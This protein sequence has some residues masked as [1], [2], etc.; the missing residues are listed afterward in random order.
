M[1]MPAVRAVGAVQIAPNQPVARAASTV[2]GDLMVALLLVDNSTVAPTAPTGWTVAYA[3]TG[4]QPRFHLYWKIA[5]STEPA[6]YTW[7]YPTVDDNSIAAGILTVE[8]GTFNT[9]TPIALTTVNPNTGDVSASVHTHPGL[10]TTQADA[11]AF[12]MFGHRSSSAQASQVG[13]YDTF[14]TG[15]TERI[16]SRSDGWVGLALATEQ[17]PTAGATGARSATW[18]VGGTATA[19]TTWRTLGFVVQGS[20]GGLQLTSS[21]SD[22]AAITD[23]HT[24]VLAANRTLTD[25]AALTDSATWSLSGPTAPT[26]AGTAAVAPPTGWQSFTP[27]DVSAGGAFILRN[28][29]DY[30]VQGQTANAN[31][32]LR[33]GR[34]VVVMGLTVNIEHATWTTVGEAETTGLELQENPYASTDARSGGDPL[35]DRAFHAEGVYLGGSRLT[36][37]IRL[38]C[39]T[40]DVRIVNSHVGM[41]RF[42]NSDHRDG[43]N[44][45]ST[46]H[47]DVIQTYGGAKS[48]TIDGL[49][50]YSA[51]Q[52]LFFK[53]DNTIVG[54]PI[55][56]RR[57]DMHA[58]EYT[59]TERDGATRAYAGHRMLWNYR[60][61]ATT[62]DNVWVQ[63]H[64]RNGWQPGGFYRVRYWNTTT[65][66][67]VD[68]PVPSNGTDIH[69]IA[70]DVGSGPD[71]TGTDAT[72]AY[73]QYTT[74][75]LAGQRIYLGARPGG[76]FVPVAAVGSGYVYGASSGAE[77]R[78]LTD[79]AAITDSA[80]WSMQYGP[81]QLTRSLADS[82]A[83]RDSASWV[84]AEPN[85]KRTLTDSA[86]ITDSASWTLTTPGLGDY[87]FVLLGDRIPRMVFGLGAPV[88]V[89]P[90][91]FDPAYGDLR[92]Q[93]QNA[94]Q[95]DWRRFGADKRTPGVWNWEAWTD[96]RTPAQALDLIDSM[97]EAWDAEYTRETPGDVLALQYKIPGRPVRRLYGRPRNFQ[98]DSGPLIQHG[99]LNLSMELHRVEDV[100]YDDDEQAVPIFLGKPGTVTPS[101]WRFP[102]R[103][104]TS[105]RTNTE[106]RV[107]QV[108]IGGR[109][110][111]WV[112]LAIKGPIVNPWVQIG[113]RR[114]ALQ[115][116]VPGGRTA[117]LSGLP[118]AQTVYMDDGTFRP[119]LLDP[120]AR[121]G[122]LR[123]EPGQYAATF[124]GFDPTGT[125]R[126][127]VRWRNAYRGW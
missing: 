44:G 32:R 79:S 58:V 74:G 50:A 21:L 59:A 110:R 89:H 127:E 22:S 54:G 24:R 83:I 18:R 116:Q 93:D 73:A 49:T 43:T 12:W 84:L 2:A 64:A 103:F 90:D 76:E 57:V 126:A 46:N 27:L 15:L 106:P 124:G 23:S 26:I 28:D 70:Q 71:A 40:A 94:P 121:L 55:S 85:P 69:A 5:T 9:T 33:G 82:A 11:L 66:A 96:A 112:V 61:Q 67:Y 123:F 125:A 19:R 105:T 36:Q 62:T 122:Q 52:G 38:N 8:A 72:G 3:W 102:L 97:A 47:P 7:T 118:W 13:T 4:A 88:V 6:D 99:R 87:Q 35:P 16:N 30:L 31:V 113:T 108:T 25:P 91:G 41:V 119:D 51:Y 104:P 117:Y 100:T 53:E 115:G 95:G 114:W 63:G 1:V 101:P 60:N 75:G 10:T 42:A 20:A 111:T 45:Q 39:P 77:T 14:T 86:A 34:R 80:T 78:T 29:T 68:E 81:Q 120:R 107:E 48:L 92:T 98:S 65:S 37:G 109:L 17:R 56:L